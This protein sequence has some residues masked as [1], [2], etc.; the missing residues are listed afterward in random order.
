MK[1]TKWY[2]LGLELGID[3]DTMQIIE[4]DSLKSSL[5]PTKAALVAVFREWLQREDNPV[6]SDIVEALKVINK[7]T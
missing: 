3:D 4:A 5:S 2:E 6:W 7:K 1:T